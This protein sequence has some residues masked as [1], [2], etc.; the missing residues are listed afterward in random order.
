MVPR[1]VHH[2]DAASFDA[3]IRALC[4]LLFLRRFRS[5]AVEPPARCTDRRGT[6]G[7]RTRHGLDR[8]QDVQSSLSRHCALP[9]DPMVPT[10]SRVPHMPLSA[11]SYRRSIP[12]K[13]TPAAERPGPSAGFQQLGSA[14]PSCWLRSACAEVRR[15]C[16][17]GRRCTAS[18]TVLLSGTGLYA[19]RGWVRRMG[20]GAHAAR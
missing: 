19:P 7:L 2:A 13:S 5:P 6:S 8:T 14:R 15:G 3:T 20:D 16:A 18:G 17:R 11:R 9:S 12:P 10:V 1:R 4:A